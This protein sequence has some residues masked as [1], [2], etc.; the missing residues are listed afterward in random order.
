MVNGGYG[1]ATSG[2]IQASTN[3]AREVE[4]GKDLDGIQG[5]GRSF[6]V[7]GEG[8]ATADYTG[9]HTSDAMKEARYGLKI[10]PEVEGACTKSYSRY[11]V[12]P[13]RTLPVPD[14]NGGDTP[15][16]NLVLKLGALPWSDAYHFYQAGVDDPSVAPTAVTQPSQ[17]DLGLAAS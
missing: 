12:I 9:T 6:G 13:K 2:M 5:G 8:Y 11:V 10:P 4:E 16:Q 7:L 17:A 1:V 15:S 3:T 14:P